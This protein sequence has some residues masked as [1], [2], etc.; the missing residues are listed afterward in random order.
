[1]RMSNAIWV[2]KSHWQAWL[3]RTLS[4]LLENQSDQDYLI[5]CPMLTGMVRCLKDAQVKCSICNKVVVI[6]RNISPH[7]RF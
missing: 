5:C 3:I 1:M 4:T 6:N 2:A 7:S